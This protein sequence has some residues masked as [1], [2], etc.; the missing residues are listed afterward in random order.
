MVSHVDHTEHD[1]HIVV[2]EQGLADIR[3]LS[4]RERAGVIIENC[5]HPDY[6]P[7][8]RDYYRRSL[9]KGGHMPHD[10]QDAFS[11]HNR[12]IEIGSMRD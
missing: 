10:L 6:K 1:V 3:G 7:I 8:L 12:F 11:L 4:P 5:A 2:T 9:R